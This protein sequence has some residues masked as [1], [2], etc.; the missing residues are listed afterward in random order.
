[1]TPE[2]E[3]QRGQEAEFLLNHP[4]LIGTL[5]DIEAATILKWEHAETKEQRDDLW[6]FYK[7][8]K[9]FR[10]AL[11]S[12]MQTGKMAAIQIEEQRRG[13]SKLWSKR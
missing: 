13:L 5:D 7:C 4:L 8:C 6:R 12:H 1:M 11:E 2:Q 9:L 10:Q 3:I